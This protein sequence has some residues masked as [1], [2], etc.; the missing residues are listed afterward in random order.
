MLTIPF[1]SSFARSFFSVDSHNFPC[2]ATNEWDFALSKISFFSVCSTLLP[3]NIRH[4]VGGHVQR[5]DRY[6]WAWRC[7]RAFVSPR[8]SILGPNQNNSYAMVYAM[9]EG[10]VNVLLDGESSIWCGRARARFY[11]RM[12]TLARMDIVS[13]QRAIGRQSFEALY[14]SWGPIRKLADCDTVAAI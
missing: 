1:T 9:P 13:G 14:V 2:T 12:R 5:V 4:L 3:S 6:R 10:S 8:C 11:R 7:V